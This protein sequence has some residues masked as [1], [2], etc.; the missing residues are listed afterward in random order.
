MKLLKSLRN[1]FRDVSDSILLLLLL[2]VSYTTVASQ[3]TQKGFESES[4][5]V[6]DAVIELKTLVMQ[7]QAGMEQM[8]E[9]TKLQIESANSEILQ[10]K[11]QIVTLRGKL[12]LAT[13]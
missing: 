1:P 10:L 5:V 2:T 4:S 9:Q 6:T 7:Q 3:D 13:I 12:Q 11:Q 8:K